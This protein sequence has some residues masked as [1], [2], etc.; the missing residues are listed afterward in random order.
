MELTYT[1]PDGKLAAKFEGKTQKEVWE[2]LANFQ[3]VFEASEKC[4]LCGSSNPRFV[5][6]EVDGNN[7]YELACRDHKCGAKLGM[8]SHK[9]GGSLFPRR[10][11]KDDNWMPNN[12]WYVYKP[13]K[14]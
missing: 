14:K 5:T 6:R 1:T 9:V 11:D 12:G 10:K 2:Q 13:G 7:F 3:E 4:G 8:G